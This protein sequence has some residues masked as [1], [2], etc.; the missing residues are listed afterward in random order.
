M[1][2]AQRSRVA[3]P[4]PPASACA[5]AT[6]APC[7]CPPAQAVYQLG[8]HSVNG[9]LEAANGVLRE[10]LAASEERLAASQRTVARL[11]KERNK[12]RRRSAWRRRHCFF[13]TP[14][15]RFSRPTA[16]LRSSR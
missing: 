13:L 4:F 15:L 14:A 6:P 7:F 8:L 3:A 2:R 12:V 9:A 16:S 5:D 11:R 10:Q 1:P